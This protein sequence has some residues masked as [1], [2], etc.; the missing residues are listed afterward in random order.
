MI[1]FAV[2]ALAM[3]VINY[4]PDIETIHCTD[5]V[6]ASN[7]DAVMLGAWWC[8]YCAQARRYFHNNEISYCEYDI[9]RSER[10]KQLYKDA[11]GGGIPVIIIGRYRMSGYD[12]DTIERALKLARTP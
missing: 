8:P 2:I 9:E 7:P 4:R 12:P 3:I 11:G 1:V 5:E 6:L 10:G